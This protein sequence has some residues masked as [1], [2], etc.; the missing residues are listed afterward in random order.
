MERKTCFCFFCSSVITLGP[1]AP[2]DLDF[3]VR[4]AHSVWGKLY[5]QYMTMSVS[6]FCNKLDITCS[7]IPFCINHVKVNNTCY[8]AVWPHFPICL[9]VVSSF[10]YISAIVTGIP[11]R[12]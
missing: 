5:I 3:K 8:M 2:N 4:T 7:F 6:L 12:I 9:L 10:V 1:A 11:F